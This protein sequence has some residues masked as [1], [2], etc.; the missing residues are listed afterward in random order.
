MIHHLIEFVIF[1]DSVLPSQR[2]TAH[3]IFDVGSK[4]KVCT[5]NRRHQLT[6][7][8]RSLHLLD[9]VPVTRILRRGFSCAYRAIECS[10]HI[11]CWISTKTFIW[12][13]KDLVVISAAVSSQALVIWLH[14]K[15]SHCVVPS[16]FRSFSFLRSTLVSTSFYLFLM[17]TLTIILL[18]IDLL[19][20]EYG[21]P[22]QL[23]FVLGI[24]FVKKKL[25]VSLRAGEQL[26]HNKSYFIPSLCCLASVIVLGLNWGIF[27]LGFSFCGGPHL[28]SPHPYTSIFSHSPYC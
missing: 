22:N 20:Y 4:G 8:S 14:T 12:R 11:C 1:Q 27:S 6:T 13:R 10:W 24:V 7:R 26:F 3:T 2:S 23:V 18:S 15:N 17:V 5:T 21:A 25:L 16:N 9:R 19:Y 28:C